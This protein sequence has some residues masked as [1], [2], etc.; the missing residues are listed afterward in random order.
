MNFRRLL[1]IEPGESTLVFALVVYSAAI[2]IATTYYLTASSALF[3]HAFPIDRLPFAMLG[4]GVALLLTRFSYAQLERRLPLPQTRVSVL[5]FLII[6]LAALRL[7]LAV[8]EAPEVV[9]LVMVLYRVLLLLLM[10][11]FWG[12]ANGLFNLSQSKR[13]FPLIS[14]GSAI[15]VMVSSFM[16]PVIVGILGTENLLLV[17]LIALS[18]C[19]VCVVKIQG[20]T[21]AAAPRSDSPD[22]TPTV[23]IFRALRSRYILLIF[24]V[25]LLT[26]VF[27]YALEYTFLGQLQARYLSSP[28]QIAVFFGV[29]YGLIQLTNITLK[30]FI[31]GRL[32]SRFGLRF[33]LFIEPVVTTIGVMLAV[34]A[35][36]T[37]EFAVIFF[38]LITFTKYSEEVLRESFNESATRILYQPLP[39]EQRAT[40]LALVEGSGFTVAAFVAGLMLII[41]TRAGMDTL[42]QRLIMMLVVGGAWTIL[43]LLTHREYSAALRRALDKRMLGSEQTLDQWIASG[44]QTLASEGDTIQLLRDKLNSTRPDEVVYA[45]TLLD[46]L[47][48]EQSRARFPDLLR[49]PAPDVRLAVL[50]RLEQL[51]PAIPADVIW[52]LAEKDPAPAV[53]EAALRLYGMFAPD[54][55]VSRLHPFVESRETPIKRGA[56]IGML[57]SGSLEGI[58]IAGQELLHL[59]SAYEPADRIL[60]ADV[61]GGISV[62]N[63]YQPLLRLL[64]DEQ[65]PVQI[66]A[67]NA[68]GKVAHPR[69]IPMM[70]TALDNRTLRA[71]ARQA[72]AQSG[73]TFLAEVERRFQQHD[74]RRRLLQLA[75]VCGR[76]RSPE[77]IKALLPYLTWSEREVRTEI[78]RALAHSGCHAPDKA[79]VE[80]QVLSECREIL[81]LRSLLHQLEPRADAALLAATLREEI[82]AGR[83]RVLLLLAL[84]FERKTMLNA[85]SAL[86]YGTT[87]EQGYAIE[88]MELSLPQPLKIEVRPVFAAT[89][90][91]SPESTDV[92]IMALA[93]DD[94]Y[95]MWTRAV[96]C[97]TLTRLNIMPCEDIM[98]STI[99]KVLILKTI[100]LFTGI[101]DHVLAELAAIIEEHEYAAG[102]VIFAKG[103]PGRSMFMI[104]RG[105]VRVHDGDVTFN[106]LGERAVFGEMAALASEARTATVTAV[107]ETQLL[108][109]NQ[110]AFFEV[111]AD[112]PEIAQSIIRVLIGYLRD[113]MHDVTTLATRVQELEHKS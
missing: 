4:A 74:S 35:G 100:P 14:A 70:I 94:G 15:S 68:S 5:L 113:R 13:L 87:T 29:L 38:W 111:M 46:A 67:L 50:E 103:D 39:I 7:S 40:A 93:I 62:H 20:Q 82:K 98:L 18:I 33:G 58:L 79:V 51:Q 42:Q 66:A 32:L 107:E 53:R 99:E 43:A 55:C 16:M 92:T 78:L 2:G 105:R 71:A 104:V 95:A 27:N 65:I 88:V 54:D 49:S 9:F 56:L 31:S 89:A 72:L 101:P 85:H 48:P 44:M 3:L 28:E 81:R 57:R 22:P 10:I 102:S 45:L 6:M 84:V 97:Y 106:H 41:F 76:M 19:L 63:F 80:A 30:F 77:V 11:G 90:P 59:V 17:V 96:L 91:S 12:L 8:S 37:P 60:A 108:R 109:L 47:E 26:W 112:Y 110:A 64:E 86:T 73:A 69:L 21:S 25:Y 52:Q 24:G 1:N 75:R 61:I 83:E 34:V 23:S 36:L